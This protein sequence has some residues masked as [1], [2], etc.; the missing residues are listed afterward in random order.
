MPLPL[1][2]LLLLQARWPS[3]LAVQLISQGGD[4]C[5]TA[6]S[7]SC[8][9]PPAFLALPDATAATATLQRGPPS[10]GGGGSSCGAAAMLP[11]GSASSALLVGERSFEA[12]PA[13]LDAATAA[14]SRLAFGMLR[15]HPDGAAVVQ[16]RCRARRTTPL[17]PSTTPA[18]FEGLGVKGS[19]SAQHSCLRWKLS[20]PWPPEDPAIHP[21]QVRVRRVW[22]HHA[23]ASSHSTTVTLNHSHTQP[24]VWAAGGRVV[25]VSNTLNPVSS[26]RCDQFSSAGSNGAISLP[27]KCKPPRLLDHSAIDRTWFGL[28]CDA[29]SFPSLTRSD[30]CRSL[31]GRPTSKR[32]WRRSQ[33]PRT[34]GWPTERS[35]GVRLP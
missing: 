18:P 7:R 34:L 12:P 21:I 26:E 22:L 3:K 28:A 10:P 17:P 13:L 8:A 9:F 29:V 19:G 32:L 1:L 25:R 33:S 15:D 35:P 2:L 5:R 20:A 31:S 27:H 4:T 16:V 6:T 11:V 23:T 30:T 24:Y 14:A